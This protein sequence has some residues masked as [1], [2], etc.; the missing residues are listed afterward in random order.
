MTTGLVD[1]RRKLRDARSA[2]DV[3]WATWAAMAPPE[4][5]ALR[6]RI[7]W[8][9]TWLEIHTAPEEQARGRDALGILR[10]QAHNARK[11]E[12]APGEARNRLHAWLAAEERFQVAEKAYMDLLHD[13]E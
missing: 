13:G 8:G 2:L 12:Q 10:A 6:G 9:E 1:I 11:R 4:S 7:E 5:V 3:A